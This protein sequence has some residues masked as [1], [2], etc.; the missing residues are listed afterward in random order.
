MTP[1]AEMEPAA[2]DPR[3]LRRTAWTL[4]GIM[5]IGGALV[6]NTYE[7]WATSKA[8]DTRPAFIHQI[9]KQHDLRVLRQDGQR[10]DLFD[11]RGRV[12]AVHTLALSQPDPS[13]RSLEVMRRLEKKYAGHD[14]FTIVSLVVDIPPI[15]ELPARLTAAAEDLGMKPPMWWLVASEPDDT[16]K[17]VKNQLKAGIF[18][19][20]EN[21]SWMHDTS[22]VLLDRDGHIRRAVVPNRAGGAPYIA[23]FDFDQAARWDEEGKLT[24]TERSNLEELESLLTATIDTLLAETS[25]I[26]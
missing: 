9:R 10:F 15:E 21:G 25:P 16:H 5:V 23:G 18:P 26:R 3:K 24:G 8:G 14:D 4:V 6:Y 17:F 2:R 1:P 20:Q 12:W 22:I 13:R 11:P 19:H 7:K